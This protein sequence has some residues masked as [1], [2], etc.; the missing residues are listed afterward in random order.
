MI[1]SFSSGYFAADFQIEPYDQGPTIS[2]EMHDY[3]KR[4]IYYSTDNPVIF[5]IGLSSGPHFET[6]VENAIPDEIIGIPEEWIDEYDIT[7]EDDVYLVRPG[8]SGLISTIHGR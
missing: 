3:I 4:N 2:R 8:H 1:E 7:S 5:R 6:N